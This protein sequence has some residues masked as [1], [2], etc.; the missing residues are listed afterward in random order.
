MSF[1]KSSANKTPIVDTV[2][3][4]VKLAK[5]DIEKNG[6][7]NVVDA[8]IGSLY[9]ESGKIVAYDSVFNHYDAIPHAT[10]A[11]YAESFKGNATYRKPV[12]RVSHHNFLEVVF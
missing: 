3:S 8:T 10:K 7:E 11:K 1:I 5:Q 6:K 2:F 4:I 12:F 9:D